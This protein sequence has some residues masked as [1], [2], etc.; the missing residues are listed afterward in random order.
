MSS[1]TGRIKKIKQPIGGYIKPSQFIVKEIN[2]NIE[3]NE[4]ENIH[5]SVVGMAVDY[6]TRFMMG[7]DPKI[8]FEISCRGAVLAHALGRKNAVKEAEK[9]LKGIKGID[10]NSVI[11]ACKLVTFDVW[12]RN[13]TDAM[14]AKTASETNPDSE[15]IK[16]IQVMLNRSVSFWQEYGPITKDGFTFETDGYT[17]T[18]NQG[19]GDYLT[20]DTLWDLKVSKSKPTSKNTLQL[21]MYWIMGK[22]S[23]KL[24]FNSIKNLGI[25]NP[26]LNTVYILDNENISEDVIKL[27]ESDVICY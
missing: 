6:L 8:A 10:D 4:I 23:K 26:R 14:S 3:L 22:H 2:D 5:A 1:V 20:I 19:D 16:N 21:L 11:N 9:F 13:L 17:Q 15:T 12:C 27:V 7:T 18:V 24:E 25:F